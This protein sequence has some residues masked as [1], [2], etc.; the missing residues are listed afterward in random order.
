MVVSFA[1]S[2]QTTDGRN[3]TKNSSMRDPYD[4]S[5]CGVHYTAPFKMADIGCYGIDFIVFTSGGFGMEMGYGCN[6]GLVDID[7]A[8]VVIRYGI[9]YGTVVSDNALLSTSLC[10]EMAPY[11]D[12]FNDKMKMLFGFS[13]KPQ[14][15]FK[16]GSIS[17]HAG[18]TFSGTELSDKISVGFFLGIGIDVNKLF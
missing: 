11:T 13:L 4:F 16:I 7:F 3:E 14:L 12:P 10:L 15:V 5:Y 17:P 9:A 1:V 2:A 18:L 8:E 6:F